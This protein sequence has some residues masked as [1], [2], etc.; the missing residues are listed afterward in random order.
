MNPLPISNPGNRVRYRAVQFKPAATI[1][2]EVWHRRDT[3][4]ASHVTPPELRY[5]EARE[6]GGREKKGRAGMNL[7][8]LSFNKE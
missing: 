7:R 6:S 3:S 4:A 5:S 2:P 1:L 8:A